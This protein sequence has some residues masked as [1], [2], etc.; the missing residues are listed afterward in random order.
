M[1]HTVAG[2]KRILFT[3]RDLRGNSCASEVLV[4]LVQE[5]D[6]HYRFAAVSFQDCKTICECRSPELD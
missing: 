6:F 4:W 3:D 5:V 1:R 2:L